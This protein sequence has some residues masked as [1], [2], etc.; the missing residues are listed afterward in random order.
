[1]LQAGKRNGCSPLTIQL[2]ENKQGHFNL[3]NNR[4]VTW[5][6]DVKIINA[7]STLQ[8]LIYIVLMSTQAN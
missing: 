5:W 7:Y 3:N 4:G 6:S 8:D 2:A 1:M